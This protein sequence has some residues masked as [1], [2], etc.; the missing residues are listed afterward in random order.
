MT[1]DMVRNT[2]YGMILSNIAQ[3]STGL[4]NIVHQC[5]ILF[6][7]DQYCW[8]YP[9]FVL[10]VRWLGIL[11]GTSRY[12]TIWIN[13]VQYYQNMPNSVQYCPVFSNITQYCPVLFNIVQVT[14][15]AHAYQ[16][17]DILTSIEILSNF[18]KYILI[19]QG[20]D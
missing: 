19:F 18:V 2:K 3:Y 1:F 7:I 9:I 16:S 8:Y 4:P 12:W 15:S 10:I 14:F 6:N 11:L 5:I 20:N 13:V 17:Y